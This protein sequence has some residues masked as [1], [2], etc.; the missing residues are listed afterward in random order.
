M[1]ID[2]KNVVKN[3]VEAI[4]PEKCRGCGEVGGFLCER[5]KKYISENMVVREIIVEDK[6]SEVGR[7]GLTS[8]EFLGFRDEILGEMVE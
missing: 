2:A 3:I 5:C 8:A 6:E 4:F 1:K 7:E